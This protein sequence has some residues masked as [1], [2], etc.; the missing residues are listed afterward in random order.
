MSLT[1]FQKILTIAV[2]TIFCTNTTAIATEMTTQWNMPNIVAQKNE[3]ITR[4]EACKYLIEAYSRV[5]DTKTESYPLGVNVFSDINAKDQPYILQAYHLGIAA[6]T[7]NHMFLPDRTITKA[8][9]AVMLYNF[10]KITASDSNLTLINTLSFPDTVDKAYLPALQF[11]YSRGIYDKQ[12]N[13]TIGA[14][15]NVSLGEAAVILHKLVRSAPDYSVV[16][17][18]F[19]NKI[20]YLTFDD[21]PSE[22]TIIILDTLKKYNIKAT[23]F[24]SG[25][26][27]PELLKRIYEEGHT[28]GNHTM[29]HDYKNQYA[30]SEAFWADFQEEQ[31]YIHN[32]LGFSPVFMRFPGG[33]N[34]HYGLE[35][36]VMEEITA[37]SKVKGY[38]YYDWNVDSRDA[39]AV[40]APKDTIVKSVLQGAS[41]KTEAI[42]LMHQSSPKTTTAQALPEIIEGLQNMGFELKALDGSSYC[43]KFIN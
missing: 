7:S 12:S 13:G 8:E 39:T 29:T 26:Y 36:G 3:A 37:Q 18:K 5:T 28:I 17:N 30:T 41:N 6:G 14:N 16:A 31:T 42:I 27:N 1:F 25:S 11:A 9:F 23:F 34:N 15:T 22:N 10:A 33:S 40:T 24:V 35:N 32:L 38:I 19:G 2:A 20:A 21:S 43:P 4:N